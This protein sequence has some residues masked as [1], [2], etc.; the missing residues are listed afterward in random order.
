M[1]ASKLLIKNMDI[2]GQIFFYLSFT[3]PLI[4]VP[5]VWKFSNDK[6]HKRVIMGLFLAAFLS[7]LFLII[8][9]IIALRNG[10]G[11]V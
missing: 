3:S 7:L 11:P 1:H 10:L 9:Y 5:L 8:S 4:T 2:F 6:K